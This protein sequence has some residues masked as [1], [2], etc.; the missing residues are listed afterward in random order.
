MIDDAEPEH[1]SCSAMSEKTVLMIRS[2]EDSLA[3]WTAPP[4]TP[5]ILFAA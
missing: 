2:L 5:S 1:S 4:T 3:H